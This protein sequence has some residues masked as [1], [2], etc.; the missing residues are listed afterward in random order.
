MFYHCQCVLFH[1]VGSAKQVSYFTLSILHHHLVPAELKKHRSSTSFILLF[2]HGTR[3]G[4][5]CSSVAFLISNNNHFP[6]AWKLAVQPHSAVLVCLSRNCVVFSVP[7]FP[8]TVTL[9]DSHTFYEVHISARIEQP[10]LCMYVRDA[11]LTGLEKA[12]ANLHYTNSHPVIAFL[13]PCSQGEIHAATVSH[14]KTLWLCPKDSDKYGKLEKQQL[15][16]ISTTEQGD[17]RQQM[18]F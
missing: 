12:A 15:M 14:D 9:I 8:G 6:H 11:M 18:Y 13:C 7:S 2:P 1:P 3:N 17:F 10:K 5:F 4:I 16:W